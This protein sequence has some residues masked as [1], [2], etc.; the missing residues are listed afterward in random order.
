MNTQPQE[1][2]KET[3]TNPVGLVEETPSTIDTPCVRSTVFYDKLYEKIKTRLP[4]YI[5]CVR[6]EVVEKECLN[7][8]NALDKIFKKLP[9]QPVA[10]EEEFLST[11]LSGL[12][13]HIDKKIEPPFCLYELTPS[14]H[15]LSDI[16]KNLKLLL[17]EVDSWVGS[18]DLSLQSITDISAHQYSVA[19]KEKDKLWKTRAL[20]CL[21]ELR[22]DCEFRSV[23]VPYGTGWKE[24][25]RW[26][27]STYH[28]IEKCQTSIGLEKRH[29]GVKE[30]LNLCLNEE[31]LNQSRGNGKMFADT[32]CN[33]IVLRAFPATIQTTIWQHEYAHVLDNRSG[34]ALAREQMPQ[35]DIHSCIFLSQIEQERQLED[36]LPVNT[37]SAA[38][39]NYFN[40]LS[41]QDE[42]YNAQIW[43]GEAISDAASGSSSE[44][45]KSHHKK[46]SI[47]FSNALIESF[48]HNVLSP[49]VWL[50]LSSGFQA[51][52]CQNSTVVRYVDAVAE[53]IYKNGVRNFADNYWT[54]K[55]NEKHFTAV[56][57]EM[58]RLLANYQS[59]TPNSSYN[60]S[61]YTVELLK[62]KITE[63]L[64]AMSWD[65]LKI[66]RKYY[67]A[68]TN[69]KK[70]FARSKTAIAASQHSLNFVSPYHTRTLELFAR[71][72]E[73]LQRPLLV[74]TLSYFFEEEQK[75]KNTE[76]YLNPMLNRNERKVFIHTLHALARAV[77][78]EVAP[79][80]EIDA[81][82][83][84]RA[85]VIGS[86]QTT[87][88]TATED[89]NVAQNLLSSAQTRLHLKPHF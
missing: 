58:V 52:L 17:S 26:A 73:D 24:A 74:S 54:H 4:Q 51:Q 20:R 42:L 12:L 19:S 11:E 3:L 89:E 75:I 38:T 7:V 44:A 36:W 49:E 25:C 23:Q 37:G 67:Y 77:G 40:Q 64:S 22:Q 80:T 34:I 46:C 65:Y 81:L 14:W 48:A 69:T 21:D 28:T 53:D 18:Q 30:Q 68:H 45:L 29:A 8:V 1:N 32:H 87:F 5:S 59:T 82:P 70:Y 39:T 78:M 62:S 85:S 83:A 6:A 63:N 79:E 15:E 56:A 88:S 61:I 35:S 50:Q 13:S 33:T 43:M 27:K 55:D 72:C 60:T 66:M 41:T 84:L 47:E 31:S 9:L 76:N 71:S 2:L 57:T 16:R 86:A 10:Q